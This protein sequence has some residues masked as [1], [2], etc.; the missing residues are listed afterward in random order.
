MYI[1]HM[2]RP[3]EARNSLPLKSMDSN[4]S[5]LPGSLESLLLRQVKAAK[6]KGCDVFMNSMNHAMDWLP[7]MLVSLGNDQ[8]VNAVNASFCLSCIFVNITL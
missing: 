1:F 2:H 4:R 8:L 6:G 7:Y 5:Y 3:Q